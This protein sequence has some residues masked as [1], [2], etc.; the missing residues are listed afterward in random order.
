M[1]RMHSYSRNGCT[2][3]CDDDGPHDS[4]AIVLLHGFPQDRHCWQLVR[5]QLVAAGYRVLVPD[6][7]GYSPGAR[8]RGRR[9]YRQRELVG[10]VVALLDAAGVDRAHVVGHDWGGAVAWSMA[11]FAP[12][13]LRSLT[14]VSTPHPAALARASVT[15]TQGLRST[16]MGLFP[17]PV[18]PEQ[19]F[20]GRGAG[21]GRRW[22]GGL[23]LGAG[24]AAALLGPAARAGGDD[25][26]AELVPGYAAGRGGRPDWLSG[27]RTDIVCLEHRGHGP[28]LGSSRAHPTIR[29]RPLPVRGARRR[30]ALDPR[31]GT[32]A[33][34]RTGGRTRGRKL[35]SRLGILGQLGSIRQL[36]TATSSRSAGVATVAWL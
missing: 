31:A 30:L 27:R 18:V 19:L 15:S 22:F 9:A 36:G 17:L 28:G 6:Q 7:R 29:P 3:D 25:G 32:A 24:P 14:A 16:Y 26:G 20:V 5:P 10:D 8:P 4:A 13:R 34:R 2:F 23:R 21:L 35:L 11:A 33:P 12:D 1:P